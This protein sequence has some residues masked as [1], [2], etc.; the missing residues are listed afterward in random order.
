M[1][2]MKKG[3]LGLLVLAI[4]IILLPESGQAKEEIVI[5][6]GYDASSHFILEED[7][8][9]YGYGVEYL[10]KISEYTGWEYE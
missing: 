2:V 3:L 4:L 6:I 9:F 8:E 10:E 1:K 5:K 7:G